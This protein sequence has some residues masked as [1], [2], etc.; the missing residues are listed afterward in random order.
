MTRLTELK[1]SLN[2][3]QTL[4]A[5]LGARHPIASAVKTISVESD[6]L[7]DSANQIKYRA[8]QSIE[9]F[10]ESIRKLVNSFYEFS[11]VYRENHPE[12]F[13]K[14]V[15]SIDLILQKNE[16]AFVD[17]IRWSDDENYVE[18]LRRPVSFAY[19]NIFSKTESL[20]VVTPED[21]WKCLDL[22]EL[23]KDLYRAIDFKKIASI[24]TVKN[25]YDT[26]NKLLSMV[27]ELRLGCV[28]LSTE[29][30]TVLSNC[31]NTLARGETIPLT[32]AIRFDAPQ[33]TILGTVISSDI[34]EAINRKWYENNMKT[35]IGTMIKDTHLLLTEP[36]E[37]CTPNETDDVEA[38]KNLFIY[39]KSDEAV[40]NLKIL[41]REFVNIVEQVDLSSRRLTK[42]VERLHEIPEHAKDGGYN[43]ALQDL[44]VLISVYSG[45]L[46]EVL[47]FVVDIA[48]MIESSFNDA[49]TLADKINTM[50]QSID[51]YIAKRL[52]S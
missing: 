27:M 2:A 28:K 13:I 48:G 34:P 43:Y 40:D 17:K 7:E 9:V 3:L 20:R 26:V 45:T 47:T 19:L 35:A 22:P 30:E 4:E 8:S 49:H 41:Q 23:R 50:K 42:I 10:D 39:A 11:S 25:A 16:Q 36:K 29:Y 46:C 12:R 15:Q 32:D 38:V 37:L 18:Q 51:T 5:V 31:I 1:T 52:K 21:F 33:T 24:F 14:D 6:H 44:S